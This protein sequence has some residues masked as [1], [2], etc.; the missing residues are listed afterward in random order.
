MLTFSCQTLVLSRNFFNLANLVSSCVSPYL[1]NPTAANLKGKT[2]WISAG[3]TVL[4]GIW[5][6][7]RFP[8]TKG[9][10]FEELDILFGEHHVHPDVPQLKFV[11]D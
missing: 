2:A 4:V 7:F 6:Y 10:S 8:E 5:S 9:R 1:V 11:I 3:L